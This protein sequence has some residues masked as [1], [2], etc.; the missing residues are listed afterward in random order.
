MQ[1]VG[2][3]VSLNGWIV[4]QNQPKRSDAVVDLSHDLA[5]FLEILLIEVIFTDG[6]SG[7]L[8]QFANTFEGREHFFQ[9]LRISRTKEFCNPFF[10]QFERSLLSDDLC[11][12]LT[13]F[14]DFSFNVPLEEANVQV[15]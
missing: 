13:L 1:P 11:A 5:L 10:K 12:I 2:N 3:L 7:R 6:M 9:R 14:E 8:A 4:R 15:V